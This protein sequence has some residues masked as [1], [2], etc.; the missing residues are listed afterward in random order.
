VVVKIDRRG[1]SR[2]AEILGEFGVAI[3]T[4]VQQTHLVPSGAMGFRVPRER[5]VE[6]LLALE[7]A[8][9]ADA[10]AYEMPGEAG[11]TS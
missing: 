5:A 6:V 1:S 11:T 9:F 10:R 2:I 4:S 3:D 7:S 8:G